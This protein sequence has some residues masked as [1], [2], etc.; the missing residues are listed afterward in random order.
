MDVL[1]IRPQF[2]PVGGMHAIENLRRVF[3]ALDT[4]RSKPSRVLLVFDSC[5]AAV[6][7]RAADGEADLVCRTQ[8]ERSRIENPSRDL[9]V[10][11][12]GLSIGEGRVKKDADS[13]WSRRT[14]EVLAAEGN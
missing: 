5:D 4:D 9:V 7:V 14:R 6:D 8:S 3:R 2:Q 1:N 11:C 13:V 10:E 12:R